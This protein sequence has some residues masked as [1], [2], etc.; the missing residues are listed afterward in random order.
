[1]PENGAHNTV[2]ALQLGIKSMEIYAAKLEE[3][4]KKTREAAIYL[5]KTH[6]D[7]NYDKFYAT[8]EPFWKNVN[9]FKLHVTEYKEYLIVKLK[10]IEDYEKA[11]NL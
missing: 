6:R 5:G 2:D 1:M 4:D 10:Q 11:G 3:F 7:Q 9:N 8:F